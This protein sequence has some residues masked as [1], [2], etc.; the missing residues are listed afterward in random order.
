MNWCLFSNGFGNTRY[1]IQLLFFSTSLTSS[2]EYHS[3]QDLTVLDVIC[4]GSK[5]KE[6][7]QSW[8]P[9]SVIDISQSSTTN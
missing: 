2:T 3:I 4:H 5:R 1:T 8:Q 9:H 6:T 7:S